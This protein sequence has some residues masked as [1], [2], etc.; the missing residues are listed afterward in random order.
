MKS[1]LEVS[2]VPVVGMGVTSVVVDRVS[3]GVFSMSV[4]EDVGID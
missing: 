1:V 4:D 3:V 2:K